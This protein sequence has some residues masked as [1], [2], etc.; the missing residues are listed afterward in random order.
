M[1][2]R[3]M[4]AITFDALRV[5]KALKAAGFDDAQAEVLT[6]ALKDAQDVHVAEL[7]TK[8][9]LRELGLKLEGE[10]KLLKWMMGVMLAGVL[11][12]ILKAFFMP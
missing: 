4:A 9:D 5:V 8:G 2:Q 7:A 12:L 10:L 11:S 6:Q 1:K 3:A